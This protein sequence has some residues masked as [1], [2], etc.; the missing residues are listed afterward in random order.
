MRMAIDNY[1]DLLKIGVKEVPK[2]LVS[3]NVFKLSNIEYRTS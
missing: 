3:L 1:I 2:Y